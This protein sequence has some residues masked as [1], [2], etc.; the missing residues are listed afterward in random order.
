MIDLGKPRSL[1][2]PTERER[3]MAL[4][5]E[6]HVAPLQ[7]YVE[8]LRTERPS[9]TIPNFDPLDGGINARMLF[10]FEAPGPNRLETGFISRDND[11]RTAEAIHRFMAEAGIPRSETVLWNTGPGWDRDI[12]NSARTAKRDAYLLDGVL[13]LL[14]RLQVAVLAGGIA[15]SKAR[16]Y[17]EKRGLP[18]YETVHVAGRARSHLSPPRS[19]RAPKER[20]GLLSLWQCPLCEA[21]LKSLAERRKG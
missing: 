3:R 5:V 16:P 2:S 6:P 1:S 15:R 7:D 12:A 11:D 19:W 4:L 20:R 14:P 9:L 17:V 18:V 13:D 10:V 21:K 8:H